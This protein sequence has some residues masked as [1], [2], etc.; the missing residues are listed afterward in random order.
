MV[1]G[2][3]LNPPEILNPS[4]L[5]NVFICLNLENI[6]KLQLFYIYS[7]QVY[8]PFDRFSF[9]LYNIHYYNKLKFMEEVHQGSLNWHS[10]SCLL[11]IEISLGILVY[12][13][14]VSIAISVLYVN[15]L[16]Q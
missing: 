1:S 14:I 15:D 10:Y 3:V 6:V 4:K 9:G 16:G 5:L 2:L 13:G 11:A 12:Q 7:L 8:I